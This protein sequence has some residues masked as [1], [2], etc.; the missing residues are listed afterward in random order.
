MNRDTVLEKGEK[1]NKLGLRMCGAVEQPGQ[2]CELGVTDSWK[3]V[4]RLGKNTATGLKVFRRLAVALVFGM[5][6]DEK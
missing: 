2:T 3:E 5:Y 1:T 6:E 4:T